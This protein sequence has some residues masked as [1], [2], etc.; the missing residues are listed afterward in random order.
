MLV[1]LVLMILAS[2]YRLY[3]HSCP[4]CP[5]TLSS[6][7]GDTA[8]PGLD[9]RLPVCGLRPAGLYSDVPFYYSVSTMPACCSRAALVHCSR[10]SRWLRFL[11]TDWDFM[12]KLKKGWGEYG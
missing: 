4:P 1:S 10:A 3:G 9:L 7:Q 8:P 11:Q 2:K 12:R 6:H 5:A